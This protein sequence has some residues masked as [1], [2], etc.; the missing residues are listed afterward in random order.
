M[1][2]PKCGTKVDDG[3]RFCPKCGAS[4]NTSVTG[5]T[6]SAGNKP[7][8]MESTQKS[9]RKS[10]IIV[11]AAVAI[12]AVIVAAFACA[13]AS[14][15]S[16]S[17]VFAVLPGNNT[18]FGTDAQQDAAC[19]SSRST[20]WTCGKTGFAKDGRVYFYS[21][22]DY[23]LC[24]EKTDGSDKQQVMR[25]SIGADG[26]I[27]GPF[28][29]GDHIVYA[30]TSGDKL[31]NRSTGSNDDVIVHSVAL[32]GTDDKT[33]Y[34]LAMPAGRSLSL[35][36][37][38]DGRI[39]LLY[40]DSDSNAVTLKGTSFKVDGSD[41][42]GLPES[43][44][45]DGLMPIE[46]HIVGDSV[47]MLAG[48]GEYTDDGKAYMQGSW[49]DYINATPSAMLKRKLDGS[50]I[51]QIHSF[52]TDSLI[53]ICLFSDDGRFFYFDQ[54]DTWHTMKDD[55]SD[56]RD[57]TDDELAKIALVD[58]NKNPSGITIGTLDD[59]RILTAPSYG[60]NSLQ[61]SDADGGNPIVYQ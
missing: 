61:S 45:Q 57:A 8:R 58:N 55:G 29:L 10:K 4:L 9:S 6:P 38:K 7:L 37:V 24:S 49:G 31:A 51:Q 19:I 23:A 15:G 33:I 30:T 46:V 5:V 12:V 47:Y 52:D 20:A 25:L 56:D 14:G 50:D 11:A 43:K 48:T 40:A 18:T 22:V 16:S 26:S 39:Y 32:D 44:L 2:C 17:G 34:S 53:D 41:E 28:I 1:Y 35:L 21:T 13:H 54:R 59:G 60:N 42:H 27:M 36:R 3:A